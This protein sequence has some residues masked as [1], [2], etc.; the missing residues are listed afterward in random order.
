MLLVSF[1]FDCVVSFKRILAY[2]YLKYSKRNRCWVLVCGLNSWLT[3]WFFV[4]R[5][6]VHLLRLATQSYSITNQVSAKRGILRLRGYFCWKISRWIR[7]AWFS[8]EVVWWRRNPHKWHVMTQSSLICLRELLYPEGPGNS[9]WEV[10]L[11]PV[12]CQCW[13]SL[14]QNI[15][16]R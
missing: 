6:H 16:L 13:S 4:Y 3:G 15:S 12:A 7:C 1:Y 9:W 14:A 11:R 10:F 5:S 8:Y 2:Q